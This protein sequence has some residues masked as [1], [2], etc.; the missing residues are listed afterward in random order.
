MPP[1]IS[2]GRGGQNS[3]KYDAKKIRASVLQVLTDTEIKHYKWDRFKERACRRHSRHT[4]D[5]TRNFQ[6]EM[7]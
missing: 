3:S 7:K 5:E 6:E 4:E 1:T 2:H